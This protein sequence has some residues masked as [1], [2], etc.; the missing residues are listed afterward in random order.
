MS[1]EEEQAI[2]SAQ[3]FQEHQFRCV[4]FS[5]NIFGRKGEDVLVQL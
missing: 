3:S 4:F 1:I 5:P 2:S